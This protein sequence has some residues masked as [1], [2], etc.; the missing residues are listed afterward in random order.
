MAPNQRELLRR[1]AAS[2]AGKKPSVS[3]SLLLEVLCSDSEHTFGMCG[4]KLLGA[5]G[6][7]E[8]VEG[9]HDGSV[10]ITDLGRYVHDETSRCSFL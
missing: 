3:L 5:S 9:R 8:A 6:L 4:P 2:D 7:H 1:Q 10:E